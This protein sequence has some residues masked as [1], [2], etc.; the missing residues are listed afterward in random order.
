MNESPCI[1]KAQ[2]L[3]LE[4]RGKGEEAKIG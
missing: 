2:F 4:G 3:F 1:Q